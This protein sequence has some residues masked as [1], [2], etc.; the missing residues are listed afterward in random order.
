MVTLDHVSRIAV[1]GNR[2]DHIGVEGALSKE[3][4]FACFAGGCLENIDKC[5][6]DNLPF[7]LWIGDST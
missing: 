2:L 4:C 1:D 5:F 3:F 6:S 7:L